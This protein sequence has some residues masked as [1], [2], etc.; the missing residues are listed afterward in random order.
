[1]TLRGPL[2]LALPETKMHQP[3]LRRRNHSRNSSTNRARHTSPKRWSTMIQRGR[4]RLATS[5]PMPTLTALW[6]GK[7]NRWVWCKGTKWWI[8]T[9]WGCMARTTIFISNKQGWAMQDLISRCHRTFWAFLLGQRGTL[10]QVPSKLQKWAA[11]QYTIHNGKAPT[12]IWESMVSTTKTRQSTC[13]LSKRAWSA[14]SWATPASASNKS[15]LQTLSII[16]IITS[17]SWL[18]AAKILRKASI[19]IIRMKRKVLLWICWQWRRMRRRR[20]IRRWRCSR[21]ERASLSIRSRLM[22][23]FWQTRCG[24]ILPKL[25][26]T[27]ART[28]QPISWM[29]SPRLTT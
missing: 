21:R 19:T 17:Q 1:M 12:H 23:L 24:S 5:R 28:I 7:G 22:F 2:A 13:S 26:P 16:S 3:M 20:K 11:N 18:K 6:T 10:T 27:L 4:I 15:Q 9:N 8:I 14:T 25:T 29:P